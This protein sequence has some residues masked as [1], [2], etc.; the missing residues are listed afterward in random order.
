MTLESERSGD[1]LEIDK[2]RRPYAGVIPTKIAGKKKEEIR[3]ILIPGQESK[4]SDHG[5]LRL[6]SLAALFEYFPL[7][8]RDIEDKIAAL[9]KEG[10]VAPEAIL[11]SIMQTVRDCYVLA[12]E[13]HPVF[14]ARKAT[15]EALHFDRDY[16]GRDT[17]YEEFMELINQG[18]GGL[19]GL[20]EAAPGAW[21]ATHGK[22]PT[23]AKVRELLPASV[24]NLFSG[25]MRMT[26]GHAIAVEKQMG[27]TLRRVTLNGLRYFT[28]RYD[29]KQ[30]RFL[31]K[32]GKEVMDVSPAVTQRMQGYRLSSTEYHG[33]LAGLARMQPEAGASGPPP[34]IFDYL[35]TLVAE[36]LHQHW[37][38]GLGLKKE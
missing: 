15:F 1:E 37:V 38:P 4:T 30:L 24:G 14:K 29:P 28:V 19:V 35:E 18:V 21:E 17:F 10:H 25:L 12:N 11:L 5:S 34:T 6:D 8:A 33:C 3:G 16:G 7:Q 27:M 23:E 26:G 31:V 36:K 2:I 20:L 32:D 13:M 22:P 9:R